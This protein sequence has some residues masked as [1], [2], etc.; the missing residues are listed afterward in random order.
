MYT[1]FESAGALCMLKQIL[2]GLRWYLT[3]LFELHSRL[4]YV[5]LKRVAERTRP[6]LACRLINM[7]QSLRNRP[8]RFAYH[9]DIDLYSANSHGKQVYFSERMRGIWLYS[10]GIEPRGREIFDSYFL[11]S[12]NIKE[13]DIIID[14]GANYADLYI[15]LSA[16][17]PDVRYIAFEPS[18]RE[19][20]CVQKNSHG[21]HYPKA[22]YNTTGTIKLYISSTGADSSV[23]EP[24]EGYNQTIDIETIS[25]NV[26][27]ADMPAIKLLKLEAEGAEPEILE[28]ADEVLH[29]IEYI[30]ADGGAERGMSEESTIEAITNYLLIRDFELIRMDISSGKGRALFHNRLFASYQSNEG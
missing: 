2:K 6:E 3:S 27:A 10:K 9:H 29:K 15:H 11:D 26:F 20:L 24:S 16:Q 12:V 4:I 25:L 18:P 22:L 14:C 19:F 21:E 5:S 30:A 23:I 8:V 13:S 7:N 28:G 1:F 17:A